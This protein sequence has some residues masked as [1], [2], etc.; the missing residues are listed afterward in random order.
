MLMWLV[1][2]LRERVPHNLALMQDA[3]SNDNMRYQQQQPNDV[4]TAGNIGSRTVPQTTA[5][6]DHHPVGDPNEAYRIKAI[7]SSPI[8]AGG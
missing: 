2:G 4:S 7:I 6:C 3:I 8:M 1:Q 5:A